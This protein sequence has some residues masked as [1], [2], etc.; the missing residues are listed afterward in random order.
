MKR[1]QFK[2]NVQAQRQRRS[3]TYMNDRKYKFIENLKHAGVGGLV[4]AFLV[5]V[6]FKGLGVW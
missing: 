5:A 4:G 3:V 1:K 2:R 6:M